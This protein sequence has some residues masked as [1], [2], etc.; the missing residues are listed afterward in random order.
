[1]LG[2]RSPL[3]KEIAPPTGANYVRVDTYTSW[4]DALI[5]TNR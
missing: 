3:T 2:I 4:L 5:G 1:M